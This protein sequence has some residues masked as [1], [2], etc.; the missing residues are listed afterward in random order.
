M[1]DNVRSV[2][3][4]IPSRRP[5]P[6]PTAPID[7]P[8]APGDRY[9]AP[10]T[11]ARTLPPEID[12]PPRGRTFEDFEPGFSLLSARRTITEADIVAFAG[13]SGDF[14]PIHTDEEYARRTVFRGRIAHGLLVQSVAAGL[15][16]QL[17]IFDRTLTALKGMRIDF[18][19]PVRAGDTIAIRLTVAERDPDPGPRRGW[20]R[21]RTEVLNQEGRRVIEGDWV[22]VVQRR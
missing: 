15:A 2:A 11:D 5:S 7:V 13:L 18:Q 10:M 14:N 8:S 19:Q 21:F 3:L 9:R 17:G 12:S 6:A 20:V 1:S 16:N 4:K 22:T